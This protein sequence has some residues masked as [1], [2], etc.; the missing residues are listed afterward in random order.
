[1]YLIAI[2]V[3]T[4]ISAAPAHAQIGYFGGPDPAP[5]PNLG[6]V[7]M[8]NSSSYLHLGNA[9]SRAHNNYFVVNDATQVGWLGGPGTGV[10]GRGH[11][12]Y[13][14]HSANMVD[15]YIWEYRPSTRR[16]CLWWARVYGTDAGASVQSLSSAG[17]STY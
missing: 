3:A 8:Y 17:C 5:Q 15:L 9:L 2:I 16:Y 1:L 12:S 10:A 13:Y 4:L 6:Y 11:T 7:A 14:R